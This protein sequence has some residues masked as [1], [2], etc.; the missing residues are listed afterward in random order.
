MK[1]HFKDRYVPKGWTLCI[2]FYKNLPHTRRLLLMEISKYVARTIAAR[3]LQ[4]ASE[5]SVQHT[6][7]LVC[8]QL[9][10]RSICKQFK[11]NDKPMLIFCDKPLHFYT[12]YS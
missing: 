5:V 3:L 1:L 9:W 10:F 6:K 11:Q 4:T 12:T 8:Q 7:A 2:V